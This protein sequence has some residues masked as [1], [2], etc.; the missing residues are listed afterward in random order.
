MSLFCL[1]QK[2]KRSAG[3]VSPESTRSCCIDDTIKCDAGKRAL[4]PKQMRAL[5]FSGIV[6]FS[7]CFVIVC[8]FFVCVLCVC[9]GGRCG[10]C[11][12]ECVFC[13]FHWLLS[14]EVKT[15][16]FNFALIWSQTFK[17]VPFIQVAH[18][19]NVYFIIKIEKKKKKKKKPFAECVVTL[20]IQSFWYFV[21]IIKI[22]NTVTDL[23]GIF[24]TFCHALWGIVKFNIPNESIAFTFSLKF[25][26]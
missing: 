11:V 20:G 23:N 14:Q 10:A 22:L 5:V 3:P 6:S 15:S 26:Q 1:Y 17:C 12:G 21:N 18:N 7:F 2:R 8:F 24:E 19:Q 25:S 4:S 16:W 9:V 13:Y